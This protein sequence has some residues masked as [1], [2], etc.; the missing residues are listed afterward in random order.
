MRS[1]VIQILKG[2]GLEPVC[3]GTYFQTV[4]PRFETKAEIRLYKDYFDVV[5]MTGASEAT[6]SQE[7]GISFCMVG[8]VDNMCHGLGAPLSM[9][10][11]FDLDC[12]RISHSALCKTRIISCL[13][14]SSI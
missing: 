9:E 8:I 7:L 3:Q 12:N 13:K 14:T 5:G 10:V 4:G 6:L 2:A 1:S 11:P